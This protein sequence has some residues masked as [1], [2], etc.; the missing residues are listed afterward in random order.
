MNNNLWDIPTLNHNDNSTENVVILI[1]EQTDF[2]KQITNSKV[3]AKFGK[4]KN[5][6]LGHSIAAIALKTSDREIIEGENTDELEDANSLYKAQRYGFELYNSNYKFR[7]FELVLSPLYP[8]KL[9]ADEG[10]AQEIKENCLY[11]FSSSRNY[12]EIKS[13][14]ELIEYLKIIFTSR[15]VKFIIQKMLQQSE[16]NI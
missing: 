8:I 12:I 5:V 1:K 2:L 11:T 9:I 10:V 13:D 16:E 14:E 7:I 4:I 3:Y 15:K 6:G